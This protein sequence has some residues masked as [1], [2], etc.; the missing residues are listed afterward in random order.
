MVS[1]SIDKK[2]INRWIKEIILEKFLKS[3]SN[4]FDCLPYTEAY[5]EPSQ[6]FE[7]FFF[8]ENSPL[9]SQKAPA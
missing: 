2:K 3:L 9:F 6:T 8:A 7:M 1:V 4:A 5:S